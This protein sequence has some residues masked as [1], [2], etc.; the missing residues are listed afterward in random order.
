MFIKVNERPLNA[1][2]II[3]YYYREDIENGVPQYNVY[4]RI[5]DGRVL[6]ESFNSEEEAKSKIEELDKISSSGGGTVVTETDPTVP[7]Y[8]KNI[9]EEQLTKWDKSVTQE[10]VDNAIKKAITEALEKEY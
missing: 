10:D 8:T 6:K 4:Y 2:Q 5:T 7:D 9:T 1:Y 3:Y